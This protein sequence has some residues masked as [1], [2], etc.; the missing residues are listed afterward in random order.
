MD[1]E[2]SAT[3]AGSRRIGSDLQPLTARGFSPGGT[4]GRIG[5]ETVAAVRAYQ[6]K[7]GFK[8][9]DGYAGLQVLARLRQGT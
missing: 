8:P 5:P 9:S 1:R 6:L 4:D 7:V 3:R 2:V